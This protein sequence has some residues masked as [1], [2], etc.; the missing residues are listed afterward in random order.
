MISPQG[1]SISEIKIV[2]VNLNSSFPLPPRICTHRD[3]AHNERNLDLFPWFLRVI[4]IQVEAEF[5]S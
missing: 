1:F 4:Q 5:G 2:G 3:A